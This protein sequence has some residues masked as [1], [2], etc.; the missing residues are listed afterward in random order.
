M[1]AL[2]RDPAAA[3]VRPRTMRLLMLLPALLLAACGSTTAGGAGPTPSGTEDSLAAG[4]IVQADNDL[5]V[6]YNPGDGSPVQTWNLICVG[7]V[8]GDHPQAEQACA[9]LAALEQPFAPLPADQM[10]TEQYG[11][12]QTAHVTGRWAGEPVDLRLSRTNGCE[13]SQWE[14]LVPLVPAAGS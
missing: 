11:G 14:S 1:S 13:I 6:E 5:T 3:V 12:P 2:R 10:C 9:H 8:D 7:F 4:G